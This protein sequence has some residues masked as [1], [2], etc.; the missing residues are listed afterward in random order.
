LD[1]SQALLVRCAAMPLRS[2]QTKYNIYPSWFVNLLEEWRF[3]IFSTD[4][5]KTL[6]CSWSLCHVCVLISRSQGS[7]YGFLIC[8][9]AQA[10]F[11][12]LV[13]NFFIFE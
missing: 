8:G 6:K 2:T 12:S 10:L 1:P 9:L 5:V 11:L 13:V 3:I 7:F 4:G